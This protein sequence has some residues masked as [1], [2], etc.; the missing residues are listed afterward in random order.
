MVLP[1]SLCTGCARCLV[2]PAQEPSSHHGLSLTFFS[3]LLKCHLFREACPGPLWKILTSSYSLISS[4]AH[5]PGPYND[6]FIWFIICL[7]KRL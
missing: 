3:S 5:C 2:H 1:Q 7:P 6:S 4:L